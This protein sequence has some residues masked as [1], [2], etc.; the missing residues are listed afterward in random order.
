MTACIVLAAWVG[1]SVGWS[2]GFAVG[3][4]KGQSHG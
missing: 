4:W 2:L 3:F 1:F